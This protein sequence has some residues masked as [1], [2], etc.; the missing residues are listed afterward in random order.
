MTFCINQPILWHTCRQAHEICLDVQ[1]GALVPWDKAIA[2][3]PYKVGELTPYSD[4]ECRAVTCA[5]GIRSPPSMIHWLIKHLQVVL[6]GADHILFTI[7]ISG[8]G[9]FISPVVFINT[10]RYVH[11]GQGTGEL[12][13]SL[14]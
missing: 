14:H 1:L 12:L 10:F 5:V 3:W 6:I 8:S 4:G 11:H 9:S 13:H 7:V 2:R